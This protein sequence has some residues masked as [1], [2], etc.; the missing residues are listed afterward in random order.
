MC[1]YNILVVDKV[2]LIVSAKHLLRTIGF[3]NYCEDL[4][5]TLGFDRTNAL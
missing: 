4:T 5:V 3:H 1:I 2:D